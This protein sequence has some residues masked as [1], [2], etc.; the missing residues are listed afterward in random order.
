M[1]NQKLTST[2]FPHRFFRW[3][4]LWTLAIFVIIGLPGYAIPSIRGLN[5][6][7]FDKFVHAC[8]FGFQAFLAF[9]AI[10]K[11]GNLLTGFV[12]AHP[13]F[14]VVLSGVLLAGLS[15]LFQS[16]FFIQRS[17]DIGDFIANSFGLFLVTAFFFK[18]IK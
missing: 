14:S 13:V 7:N 11:S 8:I 16:W 18:K 6:I 4:Y 9:Q 3:Y 17:A 15:E 1:L 12:K 10:K 2:H 5:L